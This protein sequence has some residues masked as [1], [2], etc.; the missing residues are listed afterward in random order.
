[1][2]EVK[3]GETKKIDVSMRGELEGLLIHNATT[4]SRAVLAGLTGTTRDIDTECGYLSTISIADYKN[5]YDREGVATR[6]VNLMPEE[7]WANNPEIY[8]QEDSEK[9]E[10]ELQFNTLQKERKLFEYLRMVDE[11]SGIGRFGLLL[12][13]IDDGKELNLPIEGINLLTGEKTGNQTYS[14]LY[15]KVLDESVVTISTMETNTTIPRYG[16][17]TLYKVTFEDKY[18]D[19]G[20]SQVKDVHWTRVIH[21]ADGRKSSEVY[22]TPRMK[23][24]FNRLMDIKKIVSSSAEMFW[25]GGFPGYSFEVNPEMSNATIDSEGLKEQLSSYMNGLQRYIATSGMSVKSLS[26]QVA[27]PSGHL[28]TQIKSLC[29]GLEVPYRLFVGSEQAQLASGQD[30]KTWNRRVAKRQNGYVTERIIRPFIDKLILLGILPEVEEYFVDWPDLN[31]PTDQEKAEV[32][33]TRTDTIIKYVGGNGV[34]LIRE[35]LFLTMILGMTDEEA[36]AIEDD[37]GGF[38]I[39]ADESN[40]NQQVQIE[41]ISL[42]NNTDEEDGVLSEKDYR[43]FTKNESD[44]KG[45]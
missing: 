3:N 43:T 25:K 14:L 13:G 6:V 42:A 11:L 34:G 10:F 38:D 31:A 15:L 26:P 39:E 4:L 9:T 45:N 8:E 24:V 17:P 33:L 29:I 16:L 37:M 20:T 5:M 27:D 44:S 32:A 2:E 41:K 12:L 7:C 23:N 28:E 36:Q 40:S 35:K 21:I 19:V 1:M 18:G 30:T 22:G